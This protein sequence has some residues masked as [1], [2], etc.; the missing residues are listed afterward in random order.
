MLTWKHK[1]FLTEVKSLLNEVEK[2]DFYKYQ[3]VD[4][5]LFVNQANEEISGVYVVTYENKTNP[6]DA[7]KVYLNY[8]EKATEFVNRNSE[9]ISLPSWNYYVDKEAK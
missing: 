2:Y 4:H 8:S 1:A 3:L 6:A 5:E 7:F 9:V